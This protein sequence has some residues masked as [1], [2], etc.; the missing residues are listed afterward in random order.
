MTVLRSERGVATI[1]L[2]FA[3]PILL[4][5]VGTLLFASW[6][7]TMKTILDHGARE[8]A[9][10]ASIPVSSDLR[11]YPDL[12]AVSQA[13]DEATPLLT[14]TTVAVENGGGRNA[15]LRVLVTYEVTNP[16]AVL[17]A[18]LRAFGFAGSIPETLTLRSEAEVRTE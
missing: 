11:S 3:L 12:A 5:A 10:F 9:R 13:I 4:A 7:G 14:P 8:G 17:L 16:V 1:E 18:P 2:V 15:P 6:L